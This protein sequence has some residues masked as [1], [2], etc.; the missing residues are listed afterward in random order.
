MKIMNKIV[1]DLAQI[2]DKSLSI[3]QYCYLYC[4]YYK[5]PLPEITSDELEELFDKSYYQCYVEDSKI[6]TILTE[7]TRLLIEYKDNNNKNNNLS[8]RDLVVSYRE[9]FPN[10]K[11]SGIPLKGDLSACLNKMEK[12]KKEYDYTNE[13]ILEATRIYLNE[14]R[15][16]GYQ[17]TT[18]AHYLIKKDG[19]SLLASLI[20]DYRKR[21]KLYIEKNEGSG[22][23]QVI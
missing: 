8:I 5:L 9:L 1:V 15:K 19:I 13:E 14:K 17:Y 23:S 22:N 3:L 20:D 10:I 6:V 21:D 11:I 2:T 12:F 16:N 4:E 7:K 18:N